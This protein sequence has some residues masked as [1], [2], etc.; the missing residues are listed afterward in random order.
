MTTKVQYACCRMGAVSRDTLMGHIKVTHGVSGA[1]LRNKSPPK[2][3]K[4]AWL[5]RLMHCLKVRTSLHR[6]ELTQVEPAE[7][8]K[9]KKP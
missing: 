5:L 9:Q 3:K 6:P 8:N 2:K 4:P 1:A 7:T